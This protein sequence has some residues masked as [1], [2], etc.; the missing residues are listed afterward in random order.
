MT[1]FMH[2]CIVWVLTR[3][4]P[5]EDVV[6]TLYTRQLI[7]NTGFLQQ[8]CLQG[9]FSCTRRMLFIFQ[10]TAEKYQRIISQTIKKW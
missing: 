6:V 4:E 10:Q 5:V 3:Q 2:T 8:I 7:G 9:Y 1:K